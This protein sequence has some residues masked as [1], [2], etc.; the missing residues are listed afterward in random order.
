[1]ADDLDGRQA[2]AGSLPSQ[3]NDW[4]NGLPTLT[5]SVVTLRELRIADAPALLVALTTEEVT[6]FL[7]PL[8]TTVEGFRRFIARMHRRRAAGD[9]AGFAIVPRD[10]ETAIGLFQVRSLE[11]DFATAEWTSALMSEYW[12]TGA[13]VDGARLVAEFTF[14]AIGSHRLEARA[15]TANGR[16]H[17]ALRKMGAVREGVLRKSFRCKGEYLDQSLWAIIAEEWRDAKAACGSPV[18]H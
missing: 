5:G 7:S 8:P 3:S 12:G 1:M 13:F 9:Y 6:R 17:G 16:G 4:R 11:P 14:E 18:L 2:P 15:A 10:S